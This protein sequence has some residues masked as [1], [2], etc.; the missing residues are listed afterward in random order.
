MHVLR[1]NGLKTKQMGFQES[2]FRFKE[3]NVGLYHSG[4]HMSP[5]GR[6]S[7]GAQVWVS[8]FQFDDE[9]AHVGW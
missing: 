1:F 7:M 6:N 9:L 2:M 8:D 5:H 3:M 4:Q